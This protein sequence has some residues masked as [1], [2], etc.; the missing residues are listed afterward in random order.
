MLKLNNFRG[1]LGGITAKEEALESVQAR[2][3][4][5]TSPHPGNRLSSYYWSLGY[6]A[7]EIYL[8]FNVVSLVFACSAHDQHDW[9]DASNRPPQLSREHR[10]CILQC[11]FIITSSVSNR[12]HERQ[13]WPFTWAVL[14]TMAA[15]FDAER[16][17]VELN[18]LY[19]LIASSSVW[20]F[21]RKS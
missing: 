4:S 17:H 6:F 10:L 11:Q 12:L 20:C 16:I 13:L 19:K 8:C 5:W 3:P 7:Y 9:A 21:S 15:D 18:Y 14:A 1:D 2:R